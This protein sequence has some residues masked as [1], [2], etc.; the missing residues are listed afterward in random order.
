MTQGA[1]AVEHS[2]ILASLPLLHSHSK[3]SHACVFPWQ[4][5]SSLSTRPW[6]MQQAG[7]H[8]TCVCT[9]LS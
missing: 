9:V 1:R 6:V 7:P 4:S 8:L 5:A 3:H 2:N